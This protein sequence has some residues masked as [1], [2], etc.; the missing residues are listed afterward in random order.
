MVCIYTVLSGK[1]SLSMARRTCRNSVLCDR[2]SALVLESHLAAR[3]RQNPVPTMTSY[4]IM[5]QY[6]AD[7]DHM[8]QYVTV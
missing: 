8:L 2:G 1:V 5:L 4:Y 6:R 3:E 7:N